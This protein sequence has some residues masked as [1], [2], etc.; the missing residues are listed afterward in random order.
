MSEWQSKF[1]KCLGGKNIVALTGETTSDLKLLEHGDV[2]FATPQKWDMLSRRWKQRKNVQTVGLFI[3]DEMHLIGSSIGPAMEIIASRMRF[4]SAQT[5][6]KI[7]I[8]ALGSSLANARDLGEWIGATSASIFNFHPSARPVPLEI[9]IQ[10]FN[11]PHFS[12]LML[13]MA[14][15]TFNGIS[16]SK[17]SI[18][19]VPSRKQ[20]KFGLRN[21]V[22][23]RFGH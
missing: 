18:V 11:V 6:N 8:I 20:C 2:I 7:R 17:S 9:S 12:S 13:S 14:K 3:C 22:E 10:G 16:Q 1:S 4:V 5:E 15:P 19:F 21:T 23:C